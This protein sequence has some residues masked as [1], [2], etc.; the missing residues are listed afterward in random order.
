MIAKIGAIYLKDT[1]VA[2]GKCFM[3]IKKKVMEVTPVKPRKT[4]N[5]L[6]FPRI[7]IPFFNRKANVNSNVLNDRKNTI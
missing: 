6:L 4:N 3:D 1:A 2:T 5:F 7:G